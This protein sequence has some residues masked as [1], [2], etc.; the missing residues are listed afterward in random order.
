MLTLVLF[1]STPYPLLYLQQGQGPGPE[2][3]DVQEKQPPHWTGTG[4]LPELR[5]RF[6]KQLVSGI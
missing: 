6:K 2:K 3:I 5:S 4:S 1:T